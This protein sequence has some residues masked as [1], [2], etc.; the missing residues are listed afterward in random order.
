MT[1]NDEALQL[2]GRL[3]GEQKTIPAPTNDD[4]GTDNFRMFSY[5]VLP[6][7]KRFGHDWTDCAYCHPGEKAQRRDPK[8]YSYIG[9]ACP[10]MKKTGDCPRSDQCPY[11]H[12][13]FE[14]WLHPTR[15]RSQ[16]CS[17]GQNCKRQVCFFAHTLTE[18]RPSS[19]PALAD[20]LAQ[21]QDLSGDLQSDLLEA[22]S[23][24]PFAYNN[25]TLS[26]DNT[27]P[28]SRASVTGQ[29][30]AT[31][32]EQLRQMSASAWGDQRSS[33]NTNLLMTSI[34]R[35]DGW[36]PAPN[37]ATAVAAAVPTAAPG[38]PPVCISS[39][40]REGGSGTKVCSGAAATNNPALLE[41]L[42]AVLSQMAGG[43]NAPVPAPRLAHRPPPLPSTGT[44][45]KYP[46]D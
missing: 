22:P 46:P 31:L 2:L 27:S 14:Y 35:S 24:N 28:R 3:L 15:Y 17:Y 40:H 32:Q 19:L 33:T 43:V 13:V 34:S 21:M 45:R 26:G 23:A 36:R 39:A 20:R 1:V 16:L 38:A 4:S 7:A 5:K 8:K 37:S 29:D 6:C 42:V 10:D 44:R 9:V 11:A 41:A 30:A 25:S 18:L 12:N